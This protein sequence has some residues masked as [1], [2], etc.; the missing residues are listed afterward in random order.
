MT[1]SKNKNAK[2]CLKRAKQQ[3]AS[4]LQSAVEICHV[5]GTKRIHI[6]PLARR[7]PMLTPSLHHARRLS[8]ANV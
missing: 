4:H 8:P 7:N 5:Q 1:K 3:Q 6:V 2:R